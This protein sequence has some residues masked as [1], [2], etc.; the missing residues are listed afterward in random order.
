MQIGLVG[1]EDEEEEDVEG[2]GRGREEEERRRKLWGGYGRSL[3][4]NEGDPNI[5]YKIL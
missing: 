1:K 5:M 3:G 2:E 4:R